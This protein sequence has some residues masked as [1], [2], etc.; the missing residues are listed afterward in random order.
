MMRIPDKGL[1]FLAEVINEDFII[2]FVTYIEYLGYKDISE[3]SQEFIS[4][5][6]VI[7]IDKPTIDTC[8][9]LR[10]EHKIKLPDAIIAATALVYDF[11]LISRNTSDFKHIENLH[12]IDPHNL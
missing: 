3:A 4:L 2:S 6:S 9:M 5:A 7:E 8:I 1:Q 10:K 11:V 12:V